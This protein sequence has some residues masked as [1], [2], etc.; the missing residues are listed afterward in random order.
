MKKNTL[1]AI[2]DALLFICLLN[3]AFIGILLGFFI[4]KGHSPTLPKVL[5]GLHRHGWGEI[6]LWFS[7]GM[8]ALLL[9]HL[10]LQISWMQVTSKQLARLHWAIALLILT[11]LSGAVLY[12]TVRVKTSSASSSER[13]EEHE[14]ESSQRGRGRGWRGGRGRY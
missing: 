4:G 1:R 2:V 14:G 8:V 11:L 13:M 5:W 6:H 12:G 7:L 9:L 10:I 3:S